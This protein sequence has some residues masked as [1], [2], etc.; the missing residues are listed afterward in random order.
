MKQAL[1]RFVR[2]FFRTRGHCL[3]L[4]PA[5]LALFALSAFVPSGLAWVLRVTGFAIAGLFAWRAVSD[6]PEISDWLATVPL[7]W[8][9]KLSAGLHERQRFLIRWEAILAVAVMIPAAIHFGQT[10]VAMSHASLRVDEIGSVRAYCARGPFVAAT[11]YNLAKNHIFFSVVNSLTPGSASLHPLRARF[12]SFV[13][14][15]AAMSILAAFFWRLGSPLAGAVAFALPALNTM[16]LTKVFEARGYGFLTL[17]AVCGLVA[18]HGF[19]RDR[20]SRHLW[21]LGISTA[22]GTW[23]LPFYVLFGGCLMFLLFLMRPCRQT[24]V[25]GAGSGLGI[26][27]LYAPVLVQLSRVA[28]GYDEK[29]G[30]VFE[31][32]EGVFG[33]MSFAF[34]FPLLRVDGVVFLSVLMLIL[35]LPLVLRKMSST[36]TKTL[37]AAT[38][39]ALGFY[40]FC[41]VLGSPPRRITAF[42][43]MPVAFM[44]GMLLFQILT[45]AGLRPLRPLLGM[46][47]ATGLVL[48]GKATV[49]AFTFEPDQR[50]REAAQAV[51]MLYP[52]GAIVFTPDYRNMLHA[53]L[54]KEF[55]VREGLPGVYQSGTK[56]VLLFDPAHKSS[57]SPINVREHF[58][59]SGAVRFALRGTP[60]QVLYVPLSE[61]DRVRSVVLNGQPS[62]LP[63]TISMEQGARLS[64]NAGASTCSINL[65]FA[66][67]A[68]DL[69]ISARDSDAGK[70][71]V[72]KIANLLVVP[73]REGRSGRMVE[74][75]IPRGKA[76]DAPV[77]EAIWITGS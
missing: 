19:L 21:L 67:A 3:V 75:F 4:L 45:F 60:E 2:V 17:A 57:H 30:E 59:Q 5:V 70:T 20:R 52:E 64:L 39:L 77:V 32:I 9:G 55:D 26:A 28:G 51:Q 1:S 74:I 48:G 15:A 7:G 36:E 54:G 49:A 16:H 38:L 18:F 23:T 61:P 22:L 34:P 66:E 71:P 11:T 76:T 41:L 14:V 56:P 62:A 35:G 6:L 31:S 46:F 12:W 73:L 10:A 47:V 63:L 8:Y 53:H 13:S 24:F 65:L 58:P 68:E 27:V 44:A 50:W 42:L 37:F 25:A 69:R 43:A 72:K 40:L 33:A 29:Y